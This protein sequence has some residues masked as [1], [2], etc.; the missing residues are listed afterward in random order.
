M[1]S[2]QESEWSLVLHLLGF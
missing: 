2:I 1:L